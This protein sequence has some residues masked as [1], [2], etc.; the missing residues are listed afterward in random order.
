MQI[1]YKQQ[2]SDDDAAASADDAAANTHTA[3]KAT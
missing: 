2:F 1:E 3:K